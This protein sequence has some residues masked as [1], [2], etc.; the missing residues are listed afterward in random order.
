M[1]I[2]YGDNAQGKTNILEAIYLLSTSKSFRARTDRELV[3]WGQETA[4]VVGKAS[5][6]EIELTVEQNKKTL[7]I[8]KQERKLTDLIGSFLTVLFTPADIEIV[9][10]SPDKRRRFLDQI[11]S[12]LSREYFLN[13][14]KLGRLLR[15]RNQL[16]WQIKQGKNNDLSVWDRQLAKQAVKI[17]KY[18]FD[19]ILLLSENLA[20]QARKIVGGD[21]KLVFATQA[22][23]DT[24]KKMEESY[25]AELLQI[26]GEEV[27]K[28]LTLIG[29]QRD[30]F[31]I[32]LEVEEENKVVSK[33]LNVYGSRGEQRAASLALKLAEIEIIDKVKK[34]RPVLLLDD[35]LG[36]LDQTHQKLLLSQLKKGQSFLTTVDADSVSKK[37]VG[38]YQKFKVEKGE[39]KKEG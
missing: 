25:L 27:Q 15:T 4:K 19:L 6:L 14:V 37:A 38:K 36:E 10:G 20:K 13:V 17:W 9:S 2:L 29:P 31:K 21:I 39:I 23:A 5:F 24:D 18:R 1:N 28:G 32:L 16:L 8:N 3:A 33:D 26:R 7:L 11:G 34:S 22:R 35:V 12:S 30:D